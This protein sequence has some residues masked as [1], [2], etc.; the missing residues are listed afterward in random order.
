MNNSY[1]YL[2][3]ALV[4]A[5]FVL[6]GVMYALQHSEY[7]IYWV[8]CTAIVVCVFIALALL[9]AFTNKV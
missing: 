5:F 2:G 4:V 1:I 3:C 9:E 8:L 7:G 6:P